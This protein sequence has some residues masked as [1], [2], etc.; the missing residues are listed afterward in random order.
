M[1]FKEVNG[2]PVYYE[3]HGEGETIVL[4]HNGFACTKMW[5][6]IYPRLLKA[7]FRVLMFDRR[8]YG[9]SDEGDGFTS[10]Y[11]GEGFRDESVA[12]MAELMEFLGVERFH[13]VGQCEGGVVGVD[14]CV[15]YPDQVKTLSTASTFCFSTI[16]LEKFNRRKFP[17]AFDLLPAEI[18]DKYVYWH[19]PERAAYFYDLCSRYGGC[20]GKGIFDLRPSI[21]AVA[22]PTLVMYADRGHFFDVEQGVAFYRHLRNGELAVFPKCGHNI[23]EHYPEEY[24]RQV[25][26]FIK[27]HPS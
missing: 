8:G 1:P 6:G 11:R 19:G 12:A 22:C 17:A 16:S 27:R 7:G 10:Y 15:R 18:Q 5:A 4:L 13:V 14:Y 20:Y 24:V 26:A 25:V 9:R 3:M 23:F 21:E 2:L